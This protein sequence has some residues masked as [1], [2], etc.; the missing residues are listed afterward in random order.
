MTYIDSNSDRICQ[1][2]DLQPEEM[3]AAARAMLEAGKYLTMVNGLWHKLEAQD[4]TQM[5][6]VLIAEAK[7]EQGAKLTLTKVNKSESPNANV[8]QRFH[9]GENLISKKNKEE[10]PN[11]SE[12][13]NHQ[14]PPRLTKLEKRRLKREAWLEFWLPN[15]QFIR[16]FVHQRDKYGWTRPRTCSEISKWTG[17]PPYK[18][19][20][21]AKKAL[22]LGFIA[23][24]GRCYVSK[25]GRPPKV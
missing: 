2:Q 20:R 19:S 17:L 22:Q 3:P 4:L 24:E 21:I 8:S 25:I 18:V 16:N 10:H 11:L 9:T 14:K 7:R 6:L 15:L 13:P 5:K 12:A 23:K 1:W